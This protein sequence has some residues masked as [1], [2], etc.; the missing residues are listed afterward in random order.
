MSYRA[1]IQTS[2]E[3]PLNWWI[4]LLKWQVGRDMYHSLSVKF[5]P[6]SR[7]SLP[8]KWIQPN[9]WNCQQTVTE[10]NYNKA[11]MKS[12]IKGGRGVQRD[13]LP[14]SCSAGI[15][16]GQK[17]GSHSWHS[18]SSTLWPAHQQENQYD[19]PLAG[20]GRNRG[21]LRCPREDATW[22]SS[23]T[24]WKPCGLFFQIRAQPWNHK[25]GYR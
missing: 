5:K 1:Q 14:A 3:P 22:H 25:S 19:K 24:M 8:T 15:W 7:C 16:I 21:R 18:A 20:C 10:A 13:L 17:R 23:L 9:A 2:G 12:Q 11:S 4:P 6:Q